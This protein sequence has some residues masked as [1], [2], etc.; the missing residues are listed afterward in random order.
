MLN[1]LEKEFLKESN[2]IESVYDDDSLRYA[3]IAWEYLKAIKGPLVT[4]DVKHVHY[5]LMQ[6]LRPDIA[7]KWR[8]CAVRIGYQIKKEESEE[9]LDAKVENVLS[10]INN[11]KVTERNRPAGKSK[12]RQKE[13]RD[14]EARTAHL[15]FEDVHPFEDGNGRVG[16]ML[17]EY[18]RLKLHLPIKVIHADMDEKGW[19]GEQG[20]YYK[21]FR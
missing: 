6:S 16:R 17:W 12:A 8:K 10:L 5:L 15:L 19:D 18:H 13:G 3:E 1:K 14:I 9:A 21:W 11:A 7:G 2:A 4:N 20:N